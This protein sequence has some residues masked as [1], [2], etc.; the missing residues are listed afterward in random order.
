MRLSAI[1]LIVLSLT[2]CASRA[3]VSP[4]RDD[5]DAELEPKG[6]KETEVQLPPY[7]DSKNLV[8]V[9][10]GSATS[11][12]FYIDTSSISISDDGVVRYVMVTKTEGGATNVSYEGIRCETRE[13]KTFAFGSSNGQWVRARDGKWQRIVLRDLKPYPFMLWREFFCASGARPVPVRRSV[14]ALKRGVGL[15]QSRATDE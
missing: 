12:K 9:E 7:P 1:L 11:H 10:A 15:A 4:G 6:W 8:L 14:D 5:E 3:P 13:Q 2:A